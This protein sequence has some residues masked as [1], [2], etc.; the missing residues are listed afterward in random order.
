MGKLTS[1]EA[2]QPDA[3]V[4]EA[5]EACKQSNNIDL[6]QRAYEYTRE[7][8]G[9]ASISKLEDFDQNLSFLK[10]HITKSIQ[11]GLGKYDRSKSDSLLKKLK[12]KEQESMDNQFILEHKKIEIDESQKR[13]EK[14][15]NTKK[16]DWIKEK[17]GTGEANLNPVKLNPLKTFEKDN[18]VDDEKAN[19]RKKIANDLFKSNDVKK[20]SLKASNAAKKN[21]LVFKPPKVESNKKNVFKKPKGVSEVK[22][23]E[24]SKPQQQEANLLDQDFDL[25]NENTNAP[26]KKSS[27]PFSKPKAGAFAPP[28]IQKEVK[29]SPLEIKQEQFENYWNELE[30]ETEEKIPTNKVTTQAKFEQMVGFLGFHIVSQIHNYNICAGKQGNDIILLYAEYKIAGGLDVKIKSNSLME[31]AALVE[32]IQKYCK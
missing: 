10:D 13:T 25:L 2:Y 17:K 28:K 32:R 26:P 8:S 14:G 21:K 7:P 29:F 19:R 30:E 5:A 27:N 4:M 3:S 1:C 31:N 23:K 9:I 20:P 12:K 16:P 24:E 6:R 11:L 15:W 18:K 22:E